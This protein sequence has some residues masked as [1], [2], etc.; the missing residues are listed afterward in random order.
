MRSWKSEGLFGLRGEGG[1]VKE[2]RVEFAE[3]KLILGQF[4]FTLLYFPSLSLNP[5]GP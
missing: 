5:N 1:R 4:Y 3:N 2:S